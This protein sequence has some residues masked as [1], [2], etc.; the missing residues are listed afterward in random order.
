RQKSENAQLVLAT[1]EQAEELRQLRAEQST[2]HT[3][4][5]KQRGVI[6]HL[7]EQLSKTEVQAKALAADNRQYQKTAELAQA[8][9]DRQKSE[10]AQLVLATK[11]QA[12]ELRQ[13][14]AEQSTNHTE[15]A[16][17]RG[18]I[19]QLQLQLTKAE[20]RENLLLGKL[21]QNT[22]SQV[23]ATP[24]RPLKGT[25]YT[26]DNMLST[27]ADDAKVTLMNLAERYPTEAKDMAEKLIHTIESNKLENKSTL[28]KAAK[29]ALNKANKNLAK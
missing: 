11:E 12:E 24:E 9:S 4:I 1:K 17:Q 19:E 14:R 18:V 2:N 27:S 25:H 13:L 16:K 21:P 15:I 10:N 7:Q 26:I 22:V 5:A 6:E 3:E 28:L 23:D 29:I 20:Q 8:K